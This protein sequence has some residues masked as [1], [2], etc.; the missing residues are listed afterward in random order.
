MSSVVS[1]PE[2]TRAAPVSRATDATHSLRAVVSTF[3]EHRNRWPLAAIVVLALTTIGIL[4]SSETIALLSDVPIAVEAQGDSVVVAWLYPATPLWDAGIRPGDRLVSV[5]NDPVDRSGSVEQVRRAE[6]IEVLSATSGAVVA[7][8][9]RDPRTLRDPITR[10]AFIV[11]A[12]SF[13]GT[14]VLVYL[15]SRAL[16]PSLALLS[17]SV[18]T[19]LLLM[20][21]LATP[22]GAPWSLALVFLALLGFGFTALRLFLIFPVDQS[23]HPLARWMLRVSAAASVA[24][25]GAYV[26]SVSEPVVYP[27]V[28]RSQLL[29][30]SL[31]VVLAVFAGLAAWMTAPD[32]RSSIALVALGL[33]GGFAPFL[34]LSVLPFLISGSV[35]LPPELSIV[36]IIL[37][38]ATLGTLMLR[39]QFPGIERPV[40]RS[41]VAFSVWAVLLMAFGI[42]ARLFE[43]MLTAPLHL[44]LSPVEPLILIAL[45]AAIFPRLQ[46]VA[47]HTV[48]QRLFHDVYEF[49]PTVHAMIAELNR[50]RGVAAISDA[51]LNVLV[52]T[53][54]LTWACLILSGSDQQEPYTHGI[55][56][57]GSRPTDAEILSA[58]AKTMELMT[59]ENV[60]VGLLAVGAKRH[61]L[62]LLPDDERLLETISSA[63]APVLRNALL[64][65]EL[66]DR[67]EALANREQELAALSL[68]VMR[69]Q[70]E[71]RRRLAA[72]LH[73]EPLQHAILLFQALSDAVASP[74]PPVTTLIRRWI[75][76]LND[77]VAS[78]RAISGGLR[79]PT[80]DDFGLAVALETLVA[81]VRARVDHTEIL[82]HASDTLLDVR[83]PADLEMALY[84]AAQEGISNSLKHAA[85]SRSVR[86]S[87]EENESGLELTVEDDGSP[88]GGSSEALP[89]D[90]ISGGYGLTGIRQRLAPWN[91]TVHLESVVTGTV[92]RVFV[93]VDLSTSNSVQEIT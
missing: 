88:S 13:A 67:V 82:Y 56:P 25:I 45:V 12:A 17:L 8:E 24:V 15:L 47:S 84:R 46:R 19:A 1:L 79:P 85:S 28:L 64:L 41:V 11:I 22:F 72:D 60:H 87:L 68:R 59:E 48:E 49:A 89:L 35:L 75:E 7:A 69:V 37:V 3:R 18:D 65:A 36:G 66:A 83:L 27:Y 61:D 73:D 10:A 23:R 74:G 30:V 91:G 86:V 63:L 58:A 6:R 62:D 70:E 16:R 5:D 71:E 4:A 39:R 44:A 2:S 93:P 90:L 33:A 40:R 80:M 54:D 81:T 34:T 21:S 76:S 38:P 42:G 77:L 53:L 29:I 92:L 57:G 52:G 26:F 9:T 20:A 31:E 14:G 32:Q 51:A 78:L 50:L 43:S 55:L